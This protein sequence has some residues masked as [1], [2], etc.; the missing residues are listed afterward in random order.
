MPA[1]STCPSC[2][3]E[4]VQALRWEQRSEAEI[5]VELH[6]PECQTRLQASQTPAEMEE[7]D[8]R[9]TE[10]RDLLVA[11]YERSVEESMTHLADRMHDALEQDLIG[12]DDFAP[13]GVRRPLRRAA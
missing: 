4:L 11:A 8:R 12:P 7:L 3:S 13:R 1:L 10:G 9:Q 6:C 5:L 2:G